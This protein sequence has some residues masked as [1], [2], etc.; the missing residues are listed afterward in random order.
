MNDTLTGYYCECCFATV[1][2]ASVATHV[3]DP[4]IK[5]KREAERDESNKQINEIDADD[6]K[7]TCENCGTECMFLDEG[8]CELCIGNTE[9][10]RCCEPCQSEY[11]SRCVP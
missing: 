1:T 8:Q 6:T 9:Y 4:A 2:P 10:P 7:T 5:A 11:I 3:C